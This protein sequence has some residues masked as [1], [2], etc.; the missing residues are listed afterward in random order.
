M[1]VMLVK[2]ALEVWNEGKPIPIFGQNFL[3]YDSKMKLQGMAYRLGVS[4]TALMI[5]LRKLG[6]VEH[7]DLSEYIRNDLG[8]GGTR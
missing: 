2:K 6:L 7:R 5:R 3:P 4:R 1:P 8:L